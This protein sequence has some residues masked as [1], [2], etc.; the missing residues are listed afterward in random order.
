MD[1]EQI[2]KTLS[3]I[4]SPAVRSA[5]EQYAHWFRVNAIVWAMFGVVLI[6]LSKKVN[7]LWGDEGNDEEKRLKTILRCVAIMA[8]MLFIFVNVVNIFNPTAYAIHQ[9]LMDIRVGK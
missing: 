3:E 9:L 8:G 4:G 2:I 5:V 6:Y 7:C 1:I